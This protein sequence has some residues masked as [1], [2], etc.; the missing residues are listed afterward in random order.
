M[1]SVMSFLG[2]T[3]SFQVFYPN[4]TRA[5]TVRSDAVVGSGVEFNDTKQFE[6]KLP[7]VNVVNADLDIAGNSI[8]YTVDQSGGFFL[9]TPGFN[10]Y[11]LS[12]EFNSIAPITGVQV[13]SGPNSLRLGADG[14]FFSEN[15]IFVDVDGL[16]FNRG[17]K[18]DLV[19]SFGTDQDAGRVVPLEIQSVARLY[20]ASFGRKPDEGGL[21]YWIDKF[22]A[23]TG[24]IDIARNFYLSAEFAQK[25]GAPNS[26]TDSQLVNILYTNILSRPGEQAGVNFWVDKLASGYAR[27]NLLIDFATSA[28]NVALTGFAAGLAKNLTGS[29]WILT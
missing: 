19:V 6:L 23:G 8:S 22:E 11:K 18:I 27:S 28:E 13:V 15:A 14:V 17:S 7:D 16:N 26:L 3:L 1:G 12:D 10:G 25:F 5:I 21:N 9:S 20:A 29:D 24:F 4:L 2:K